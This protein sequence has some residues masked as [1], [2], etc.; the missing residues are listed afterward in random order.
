MFFFIPQLL[1]AL[2]MFGSSLDDYLHLLVPPVVKLF[3][4]SDI[5][6][7][8]RKLVKCF[9]SH[10]NDTVPVNTYICLVDNEKSNY[11]LIVVVN[12][13]IFS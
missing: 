13:S 7:T 5:P 1:N 2:Q 3:D 12:R 9:S 11:R 10:F 4:S 6:L 8:V